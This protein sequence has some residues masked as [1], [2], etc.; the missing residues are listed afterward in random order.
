MSP[1]AENLEKA[2]AEYAELRRQY[3]HL[4]AEIEGRKAALKLEGA[5]PSDVARA[6]AYFAKA[7]PHKGKK[8]RLLLADIERL[9]DEL[10][11]VGPKLTDAR[12]ELL[13]AE[14]VEARTRARRV[15]PQ[16]LKI[17]GEIALQLEALA[18]LLNEESRLRQAVKLP[19]GGE[20]LPDL[21]LAALG[22]AADINS[23]IS[24]WFRRARRH[25]V[26]I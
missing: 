21:S 2:R 24:E 22:T 23:P 13:A 19:R 4:T 20:A 8:R 18:G 17:A 7:E 26:V 6:S 11:L 10:E 1:E 12:E 16:H 9:E 3:D 5:D 14:T 15:A 25:G